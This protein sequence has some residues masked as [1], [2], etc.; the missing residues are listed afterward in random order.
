[1]TGNFVNVRLS[2]G[3]TGTIGISVFDVLGKEV[4]H[5]SVEGAVEKT[6]VEN[7]TIPSSQF[8]GGT[9]LVRV[10]GEG[11]LLTGKFTVVR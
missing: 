1:V 5:S 2:V 7:F 8:P 4:Y 10:N 9:Y 6:G 11:K 3:T